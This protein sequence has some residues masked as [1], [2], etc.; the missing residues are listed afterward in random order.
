MINLMNY[1]SAR[2][3]Q[4]DFQFAE[5]HQL[6]VTY[7]IPKLKYKVDYFFGVPKEDAI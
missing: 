6:G 3:D 7:L 4:D 5:K 2:V 1:S